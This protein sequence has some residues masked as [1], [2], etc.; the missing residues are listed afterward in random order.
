MKKLNINGMTDLCKLAINYGTD[1]V[2]KLGHTYTPYY[3]G[4]FKNRRESVKKVLEIGILSGASLFMWRD[5][6]PNAEIY[7]IDI[8]AIELDSPRIHCFKYDQTDAKQLQS[9]IDTAGDNFD[10]IVDDGSHRSND[11]IFTANFLRKYLS[12]V[13]IYVIEDVRFPN[14]VS[15]KTLGTIVDLGKTRLHPRDNRLVIL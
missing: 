10:L 7:G 11:Q 12:S 2:P 15:R 3:H 14:R 1:K 9:F 8:Q 13:G 6:F 4:L 5:Y